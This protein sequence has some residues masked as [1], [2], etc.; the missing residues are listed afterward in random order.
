MRAFSKLI[1][2]FH[3]TLLRAICYENFPIYQKF[4]SAM[5]SMLKLV[6]FFLRYF[7]FRFYSTVADSVDV[8]VA[9]VVVV[10]RGF[11]LYRVL[12]MG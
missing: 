5:R 1:V 8:G 3:V 7:I 9:F 6:A 10:G 4:Y 12:F 11:S 2:S